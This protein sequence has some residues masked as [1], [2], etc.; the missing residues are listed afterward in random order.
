[1]PWQLQTSVPSAIDQTFDAAASE[2]TWGWFGFPAVGEGSTFDTPADPWAFNFSEV[3]D[4]MW[5]VEIGTPT[6]TRKMVVLSQAIFRNSF[7]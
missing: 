5:T 3:A 6:L 2:K 7:Y 1:M 4:Y